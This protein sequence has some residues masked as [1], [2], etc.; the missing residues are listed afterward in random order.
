ML[1][2]FLIKTDI[3]SGVAGRL[4]RNRD[5]GAARIAVIGE[6]RLIRHERQRGGTGARASIWFFIQLACCGKRGLIG[7]ILEFRI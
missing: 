7:G 5:V 1:F 2:S 6:E 4:G 3:S